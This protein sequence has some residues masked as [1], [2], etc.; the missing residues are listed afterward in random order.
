[1]SDKEFTNHPIKATLL[2]II[3]LIVFV[4][5]IWFGVSMAI[6][7]VPEI[8]HVFQN[9]SL[10][11]VLIGIPLAVTIGIANY[12]DKGDKKRLTFGLVSTALLIVYFVMVL[13]SINLGFEGEEYTY[14]LTI[15]G[16]I[17]LTIIGCAI[18]GGF[19]ALE[20]HTYQKELKSEQINDGQLEDQEGDIQYY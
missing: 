2:T 8:E 5:L 4:A 9:T 18:R 19:Y 16:I 17:I 10:Y 13:G 12:F 3:S 6:T 11:A 15:T 7:E 14:T 1:M 20:F